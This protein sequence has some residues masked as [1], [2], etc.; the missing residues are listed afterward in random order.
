MKHFLTGLA[1]RILAVVSPEKLLQQEV[2]R[3]GE[4]IDMHL[5]IAPW[6]HTAQPLIDELALANIST[7]LLFNPYPK[8]VLPFDMNTHTHQIAVESAGRIF[9]LASLNTTHDNWEEHRQE[10]VDRLATFLEKPEVLGTKLAPPHTCL[11]LQSPMMDDIVAVVNQ[12]STRVLASHI[13]TTPF[14][15]PLGEQLG[16]ELCCKK[17]YVDPKLL[18][19]K[20]QAYPDVTFVLLHAGH[21]FL[22]HDSSDFYNFTFVD[23]SI[24]MAKE[25][26]NVYISLS[27][28]FALDKNKNVLKYP[29]GLQNVQ[30]MRRANVTHKV[31]WGSDAS[32]FRGQIKPV[33]IRSVQAMVRAGF[34]QEERCWALQGAARHVFQIPSQQQKQPECTATTI[35]SS[36]K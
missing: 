6:F 9:S 1:A 35:S 5:H 8:I 2:T 3:C 12:S 15:G 7:G 4:I 19:P 24:A 34:T 14:C 26:P 33:L 27:A 23:D 22:P 13:G 32:Y 29:G 28:M 16:L 11:P 21:E 30:K 36:K 20:I 18:I 25:Y 31:L 17:E 10:E